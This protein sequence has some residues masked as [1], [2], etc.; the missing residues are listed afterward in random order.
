M[1][2]CDACETTFPSLS[3]LKLHIVNVHNNVNSECSICGKSFLNKHS[4]QQHLKEAHSTEVALFQCMECDVKEYTLMAARKH[5]RLEHRD[6][7][8]RYAYNNNAS[9]YKVAFKNVEY[10]I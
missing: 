2:A 5:Y 8:Y 1:Y 6:K 10:I 3:R 9:A 4:L 7:H